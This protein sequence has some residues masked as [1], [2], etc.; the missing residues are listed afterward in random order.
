MSNYA[1]VKNESICK[2]LENIANFLREKDESISP[3][4]RKRLN[5]LAVKIESCSSE[6]EA[7]VVDHYKGKEAGS[8]KIASVLK[9]GFKLIPSKKHVKMLE[10]QRKRIEE[11][12]ECFKTD[13]KQLERQFTL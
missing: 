3:K 6:L 10:E 5:K 11:S 4:I 7:I 8:E 12:E 1:I 9:K 13:R 2:G